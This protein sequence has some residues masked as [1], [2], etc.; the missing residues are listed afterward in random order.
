MRSIIVGAATL[1]IGIAGGAL[2]GLVVELVTRAAG[3]TLVLALAGLIAA[4]LYLA[5]GAPEESAATEE[6]GEAS[7]SGESGAEPRTDT[8]LLERA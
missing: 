3:W 5:L 8:H 4:A 6:D 7:S 2:V 1:V